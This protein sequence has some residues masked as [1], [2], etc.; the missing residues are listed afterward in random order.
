MNIFRS[1]KTISIGLLVFLSGC[2]SR[3][4]YQDNALTPVINLYNRNFIVA[5][6][7]MI[8]NII[9]GAPI[10]LLTMGFDAIFQIKNDY[11][12]SEALTGIPTM[13]CGA[14]LGTL[15]IPVSYICPE[16]AWYSGAKQY[17]LNWK[18][19]AAPDLPIEKIH[20]EAIFPNQ[21]S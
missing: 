2:A 16:N 8:G 10:I 9:C 5:A 20:P 12:I 1:S 13:M 6:P 17:R 21:G 18:C 4:E 3:Y 15:F 11:G 7:T 14:V 19:E